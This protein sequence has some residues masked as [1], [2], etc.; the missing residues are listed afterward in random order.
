MLEESD[1]ALAVTVVLVVRI[2]IALGWL[3]LIYFSPVMFRWF[4]E[5]IKPF[6]CLMV[7]LYGTVMIRVG[8]LIGRFGSIVAS[9]GVR[10]VFR[11]RYERIVRGGVE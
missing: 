7:E 3:V 11:L 10:I 2:A 1:S 5:L 8:R 6:F 9:S 4:F